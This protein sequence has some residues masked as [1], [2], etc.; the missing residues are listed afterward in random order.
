MEKQAKEITAFTPF[1]DATAEAIPSLLAYAA[2]LQEYVIGS[3]AKELARG[4]GPVIQNFKGYLGEDDDLFEGRYKPSKLST[5]AERLWLARPDLPEKASRIATK[6][7][8]RSFLEKLFAKT[9]RLP[10]QLIIGVPAVTDERWQSN[11]RRHARQVLTELGY[12]EPLFFPEPF[13]VFQYYRH[14]ENLLPKS[15]QPL[16]VLI[17]DFG[18]GTFDCCIV[19]TTAEGNLARGG[20]TSIPL[21]VQSVQAAGKELDRRLMEIGV[22]KLPD[23]RLKQESVESRIAARPWI[24]L[25]AEEIKIALSQQMGTC[26]LEEDCSHIAETSRIPLGFYRPEVEFDLVLTGEDLKK[27]IKELWFK[28][29][30]PAIVKTLNEVKYRRRGVQLQPLDKV[31]L[32]GGSSG[33]P[34]LSQLV[35]KT[36]AGQVGFNPRD[37]VVGE[38]FEK[39]VAYGL[40]FEARE[41]RKR[42]LRTHHSIGPCVFNRLF[43]YVAARRNEG[44]NKP[45]IKRIEKDEQ[46]NCDPGVLLDGPMR[47]GGFRTE[48]SIKLPF[49]PPGSLLFWFC[50]REDPTDPT[51]DRLNIRQDVLRLP[52]DAHKS[53]TLT[54]EFGENGLVKPTFGVDG[55]K[56]EASP[57]LFPN[58]RL[59]KE[60]ESFAGVDL[61]TSN[62]YVVNLWSER[63]FA[64]SKYPTFT[65]TD[66]TGQRLRELESKLE[67]LRSR[68]EWKPESSL[69]LARAKEP[70]FIFHSIKIEGSALTRGDTDDLLAGRKT[71]NTKEMI[72]P[73]NVRAAYEFVLGNASSVTTA[74][75]IFLR[76]INRM[77]L[78]GLDEGGG[79]LRTGPVKI[80]GMD[81][82]P[83]PAVD[84]PPYMESLAN[85]LKEGA[86]GKSAIH[87]AAEMHSKL[88]AI[89]PFVDG[90]GRTARLLMNAILVNAGV[91]PAIINFHDKQRYLDGLVAGNRGDLS[92]T[93][94]LL[95]EI[96]EAAL[97]EPQTAQRKGQP[98]EETPT[99]HAPIQPKAPSH[100]LAEV[101]REKIANLP[102]DREARYKGWLAAFE[103]FRQ[104][105]Q[106]CCLG[107]NEAY[108]H[109]PYRTVYRSYDILPFDKYDSLL[110]D[111]RT[112]RTW[113]M[114]VDIRSEEKAERFVFFFQTMSSR[115]KNALSHAHI[116]KTLPQT[117]VTLAVSRWS[118]GS[119]HRL[120][121]EP[122]KLREVGY[123]SGE[124]VFLQESQIGHPEIKAGP[125]AD[126]VSDFLADAIEAFL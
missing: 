5:R 84:V 106:L 49:R 110:R 102:I 100:R 35:A 70:D 20:A 74:P 80:A 108:S 114:G 107:F 32:A 119:F 36:L 43:L 24:L 19:E 83:P 7:V 66:S 39:A 122:V 101:M 79:N 11:Y 113:L 55:K 56:L 29:W 34:F 87:F 52:P 40:A 81:Y 57:F 77:I 62:T 51:A 86:K 63:R 61:G 31:I 103:S 3:Q 75:G 16:A 41:Q 104:Q 118:D 27:A 17:V 1:S 37:I 46:I 10:E 121:D 45:Y 93:V 94:E 85:E 14:V 96:I 8:L 23:A 99:P 116:G 59:A 126:L 58:L 109:T 73:V 22:G 48:Y 9:G 71:A 69:R 123:F 88:V 112:P 44:F 12:A 117:D 105:V 97:E 72:E 50:D 6:Q 82:E 98:V 4:G 47:V 65:I 60:V 38:H 42:S 125:T 28:S 76:E 111:I 13:A 95:A 54:L 120:S 53:F 67:A 21:G 91:P 30:G 89:H 18:G 115:F 15:Y 33:L 92:P 25:L 124:V 90:N 64:E 68:G 26:R 78:Q 2:A